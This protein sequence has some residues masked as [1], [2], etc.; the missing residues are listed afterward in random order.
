MRLLSI[1]L[2][3]DHFVPKKARI[4]A[5]L[6]RDRHAHAG[7]RV[8]LDTF[9]LGVAKEGEHRGVADVFIDGGAEFQPDPR[10]L[11]EIE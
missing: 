10:H 5:L 1:E 3:C 2:P 11:G 4:L 8:L 9:R 6:H 7:A